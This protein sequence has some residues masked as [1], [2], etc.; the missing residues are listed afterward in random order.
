MSLP[1]RAKLRCRPL[2]PFECGRFIAAYKFMDLVRVLGMFSE[3]YAQLSSLQ[4]G[5][6]VNRLI[7]HFKSILTCI[8]GPEHLVI[9][10][11]ISQSFRSRDAEITPPLFAAGP[12]AVRRAEQKLKA[13][14]K[15]Q[16]YRIA[17]WALAA[18]DLLQKE[19]HNAVEELEKALG[20][21]R[22]TVKNW[23]QQLAEDNA[24]FRPLPNDAHLQRL[25]FRVRVCRAHA[26]Q[27]GLTG[28]GMLNLV[29]AAPGLVVGLSACRRGADCWV[30]RELIVVPNCV[31]VTSSS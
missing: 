21:G 18:H 6:R 2:Q 19:G 1:A 3:D 23:L 16:K 17:A 5:Q 14:P 13:L 22:R 8:K 15:R 11:D 7:C 25:S 20:I 28:K 10:D 12:V 24:R 9:F 4:R 30:V 27:R 29:K 26:T 31:G